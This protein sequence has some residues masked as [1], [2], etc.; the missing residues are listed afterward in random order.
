MPLVL[1]PVLVILHVLVIIHFIVLIRVVLF[2]SVP[3]LV[4]IR[5]GGVPAYITYCRPC[6]YFRSSSC[7]CS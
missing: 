4:L 7:R 1:I 2:F 6:S 3:V 5:Q